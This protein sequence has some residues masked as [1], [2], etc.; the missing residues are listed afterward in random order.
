MIKNYILDYLDMRL[1]R[2]KIKMQCMANRVDKVIY[3]RVCFVYRFKNILR[4]YD[5]N[6]LIT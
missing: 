2:C 3:M 6:K 4:L 1:N 5:A